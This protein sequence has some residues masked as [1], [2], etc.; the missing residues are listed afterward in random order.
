[1]IERGGYHA[2]SIGTQ[3]GRPS[4]RRHQLFDAIFGTYDVLWLE[5]AGDLSDD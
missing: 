5:I 3:E 4:L 2:F 1:M